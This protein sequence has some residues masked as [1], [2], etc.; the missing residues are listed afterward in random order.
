VRLVLGRLKAP[1]GLRRAIGRVAPKLPEAVAAGDLQLLVDVSVLVSHD[2]GTGIQR[3]TKALLNELAKSP[4]EG[5][6]V[7]PVQASR[8]Q[9]YRYVKV[10]K[11]SARV[12]VR[13]GDV[14]LGLDLASRIL[15]RHSLQLLKWRT[16]GARLC[17]VMYDLLPLLH[18]NWFTRRNSR[19]YEAWI[20]TVA[21]HADSVACISQSVARQFGAWLASQGF[22]RE[23]S[24]Q[25][26]WFHLGT[27]LPCT[28]P[29]LPVDSLI[30]GIVQNPFVLMVGTIE[31]RKGYA[32]ALDA[33]DALWH[34]GHPMQLVIVGRIGWNVDALLARLRDHPEIGHRLHW[35]DNATDGVLHAL[36]AAASGVL[37][38][39]EA[40][41]FGLPILEAAAYRKPLL[42]RNL[43]VFREVAGAA[44][45][46]FNAP[47]PQHFAQELNGWLQEITAGTA[48][49]A[50]TIPRK[51]WAESAREL[52]EQLPLKKSRLTAAI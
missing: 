46:Y 14:F 25:V 7:R 31:P 13:P 37:I 40:E 21:V 11:G 12:Q 3:V 22:D 44:A 27:S 15:P 42:L 35:L 20:R 38:T 41:G 33:F 50:A 28:Q 30:Q 1:A 43:P 45:S 48:I 51:T 49:T 19:A 47:T 32:Q 16:S 6:A 10:R 17:I 9:G 29:P 4:P 18:P 8:W 26:G 23:A 36:Y 39:S 5:Y 2:A 34:E 24:P 52:L